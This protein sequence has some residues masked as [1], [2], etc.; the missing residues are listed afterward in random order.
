M[1][2]IFLRLLFIY[3]CFLRPFAEAVQAFECIGEFFPR[4]VTREKSQW[5]AVS[6][7]RNKNALQSLDTRKWP[8]DVH[9][10]QT[11]DGD[12]VELRLI[13]HFFMNLAIG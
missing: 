13:L 4:L 1:C 12:K 7:W 5:A 2:G 11:A 6:V 9:Y 8:A 10:I 3:A